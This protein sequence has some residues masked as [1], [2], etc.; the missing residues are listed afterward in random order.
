MLG[1]LWVFFPAF[2]YKQINHLVEGRKGTFIDPCGNELHAADLLWGKLIKRFEREFSHKAG[3]RGMGICKQW[4]WKRSSRSLL[5]TG[6]HAAGHAAQDT[7]GFLGCE[8]TLLPALRVWRR[9]LPGA[10]LT[11]PRAARMLR[12]GQASS[13]SRRGDVPAWLSRS[14]SARGRV[15]L[16]QQKSAFLGLITLL[17]NQAAPGKASLSRSKLH[18]RREEMG[19]S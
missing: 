4:G 8:R 11:F 19:S 1:F 16:C 5:R 10:A 17:C 13:A 15:L 7:I 6:S 18:P 3:G 9:W 2:Y 12:P 14:R